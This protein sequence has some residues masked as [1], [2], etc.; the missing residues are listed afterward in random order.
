MPATYFIET[1]GC[2][3]NV[4][5]SERIA[6]LLERAG[7]R[8]AP[9]AEAADLIVLNTCSVREKAEDKLFSRLGELRAGLTTAGG[10]QVVA[11]AGCVA[12]Q[13]GSALL[14]RAPHVGVVVGTR[15]QRR[16]VELVGAVRDG[17]GPRV[18]IEPHDEVSFPLGVARRDSSAF[19]Y[20]W[21]ILNLH[22]WLT[23]F[24]VS[25]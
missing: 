1:M 17:D 4:H 2:Q 15:A 16:L 11:V 5:D 18:D 12:Q 7:Y 23:R 13:E 25:L 24:E 8:P 6:G 21:R 20:V 19:L 3:M 22:L 10:R 14:S 9:D